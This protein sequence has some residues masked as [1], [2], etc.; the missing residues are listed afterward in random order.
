MQNRLCMLTGLHHVPLSNAGRKIDSARISTNI[1][2]LD[3]F[4][5]R[6]AND[7]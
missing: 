3:A 1:C 6:T 5:F 4:G 2:P 7:T